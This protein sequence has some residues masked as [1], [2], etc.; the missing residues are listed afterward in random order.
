MDQATNVTIAFNGVRELPIDLA[1]HVDQQL[2]ASELLVAALRDRDSSP[3]SAGLLAEILATR[4]RLSSLKAYISNTYARVTIDPA[5]DAY[6][7]LQAISA[8]L[9][10]VRN[11]NGMAH[12]PTFDLSLLVNTIKRGLQIADNLTSP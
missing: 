6:L 9:D 5:D 11:G 1:S 12:A 4:N 2:Q 3:D 8:R 10:R 7:L